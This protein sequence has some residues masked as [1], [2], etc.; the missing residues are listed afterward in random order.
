MELLVTVIIGVIIGRILHTQS[1]KW[2]KKGYHKIKVWWVRRVRTK[3]RKKREEVLKVRRHNLII[4][5]QK[6]ETS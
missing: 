1:L 5:K 2:I 3:K 6:H 4:N